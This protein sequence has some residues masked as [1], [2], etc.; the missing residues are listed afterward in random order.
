[1]RKSVRKWLLTVV[2]EFKYLVVLKLDLRVVLGFE[3]GSRCFL[4]WWSFD[5]FRYSFVVGLVFG[6][7]VFFFGSWV[8]INR[9]SDI[10]GKRFKGSSGNF[11]F[12]FFMGTWY[13]S[14]VC[15]F[16]W[17]VIREF[18]CWFSFI[19]MVWGVRVG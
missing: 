8:S 6:I 4:E 11:I 7:R 1:M 9:C 12:R 2:L 15:V 17:L 13:G 5:V 16:G 19:R 14:F 3:G 18:G 10:I